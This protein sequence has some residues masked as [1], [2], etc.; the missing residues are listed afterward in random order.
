ME[1]L[2]R[3]E[4]ARKSIRGGKGMSLDEV[5]TWARAGPRRRLNPRGSS[6]RGG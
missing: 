5:G 2:G 4:A 3:I 6:L 1:C